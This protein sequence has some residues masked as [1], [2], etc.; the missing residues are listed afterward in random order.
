MTS[1][2][3]PVS[4]EMTIQEATGCII[5]RNSSGKYKICIARLLAQI[6]EGPIS[7]YD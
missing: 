1:C 3:N 7:I 5:V 2:S 4:V 6:D